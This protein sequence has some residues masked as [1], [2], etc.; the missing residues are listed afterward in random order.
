MTQALTSSGRTCVSSSLP[1]AYDREPFVAADYP[2][3]QPANLC[4]SSSPSVHHQ[5][6][7]RVLALAEEVRIKH[8]LKLDDLMKPSSK[9]KLA[10]ARA[11][12]W[13]R[14]RDENPRIYTLQELGKIFGR[15][16]ATILIGVR[17][18][19]HRLAKL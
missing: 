5:K 19:R 3:Q 18:Y 2:F 15:H 4:V 12:L 9:R 10:W 13:A 8:R 7:R 1:V 6:K 17:K 16:H 11:E 14:L